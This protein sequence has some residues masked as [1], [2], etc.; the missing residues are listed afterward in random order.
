MDQT[1]T[2][3]GR[4]TRRRKSLKM[5]PHIPL[6]VRGLWLAASEEQ[7]QS[8][9]RA[10]S[11]VLETWLGRKSRT[12]AAQELAC[13]PVRF[14][15][16]SQQAVAGMVA[17]LLVQPKTRVKGVPMASIN[18]EED[19]KKLKKIIAD[20]EYR[21]RIQEELIGILRLLPGN[22][23]VSK[24]EKDAQRRVKHGDKPKFPTPTAPREPEASGGRLPQEPGPKKRP[25][26][27]NPEDRPSG[28]PAHP[29][30]LGTP[31]AQAPGPSQDKP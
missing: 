2:V 28:Q 21:V 4:K 13:P 16:L 3:P 5:P 6:P 1:T 14:W 20:L 9:H 31:P 25:R 29:L 26:K 7:K 12:Q 27:T 11:L 17:G 10:A 18:P 15:Q 30:E 19:P 24:A 22:R 23:L 8:A